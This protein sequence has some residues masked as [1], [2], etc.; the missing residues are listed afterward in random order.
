MMHRK[1]FFP[2]FQHSKPQDSGKDKVDMLVTTF[3]HD[4]KEKINSKCFGP[5]EFEAS[6]KDS[7]TL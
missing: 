2:W 6:K 7:I 1:H 5:Q 3:K 4:C